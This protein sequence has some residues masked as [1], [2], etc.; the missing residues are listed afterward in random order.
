MTDEYDPFA[1]EGPAGDDGLVAVD[2]EFDTLRDFREKMA[3]YLGD[4]GFFARSEKPLPRNTPVR[5]RFVLPEGFALAQG[6]ATVAWTIDP[7]TNP[8]LIPGMA[9]RFVEVGRQSRAVIRELVDF[10]IATGGD[11]FDLGP[12]GSEPGEIPTDALDAGALGPDPDADFPPPSA[13]PGEGAGPASGAGEEVLPDWLAESVDPSRFDFDDV[14]AP[15][16]DDHEPAA[17]PAAAGEA[18]PGEFEVDLIFDD[19]E[20]RGAQAPQSGGSARDALPMTSSDRTPPRD[21]R[22]GLIVAAALAVVAVV[23][24]VWSLWLRP[25]P[26]GEAAAVEAAEGAPEPG[27]AILPDPVEPETAPSAEAPA[28]IFV[29]EEPPPEGVIAEEAA[30]VPQP[31]AAAAQ[32]PGQRADRILDIVAAAREGTTTVVIR[33]N[34]LIGEESVRISRLEDPARLWVRIRHIE[35]F[36]RPNE[37]PVGSPEVLQVR[38]GHHPEDAPPS[39]WVVVDLADEAMAV[40]AREFAGDTVRLSVGRP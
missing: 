33:G 15:A 28:K 26:T 34:G 11:A 12:A 27:V 9:L 20:G 7:E 30:P 23:V 35:T 29:A 10:H 16:R 2:L 37:I 24:L 31:T 3:P 8:D 25:Q 22:L 1:A 40:T 13:R 5:F 32:N 14:G 18:P 6:T 19:N 21:L 17:P 36:Y 38:V 39:L 4:R